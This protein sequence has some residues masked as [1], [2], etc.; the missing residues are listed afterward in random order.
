MKISQDS[1]LREPI[2]AIKK[3]G[4]KAAAMVQDFLTLARRGVRVED[5]INLNDIVYECVSSPEFERIKKNN[6]N[7][8]IE[9]NLQKGLENIQG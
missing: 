1:P 3:S 4:L 6:P 2:E 5:V 7:V 9:V 8:E